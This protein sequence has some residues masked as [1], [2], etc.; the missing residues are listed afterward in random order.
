M[1]GVAYPQLYLYTAKSFCKSI[2]KLI[3]IFQWILVSMILFVAKNCIYLLICNELFCIDQGY[4]LIIITNTMN[5]ITITSNL[6]VFLHGYFLQYSFFIVIIK[7][8]N[9]NTFS[10]IYFI[11]YVTVI[12]SLESPILSKL[13]KSII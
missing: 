13:A 4:Q 9:F 12:L 11:F 5:I 8:I 10:F 1:C 2:N 3:E 7:I 6:N